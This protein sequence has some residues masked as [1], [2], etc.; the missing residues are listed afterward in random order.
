MFA[1]SVWFCVVE[2][3][4]RNKGVLPNALATYLPLA[5]PSHPA[6]YLLTS[7]YRYLLT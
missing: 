2:E 5:N 6:D 3:E 7:A 4:L 1:A